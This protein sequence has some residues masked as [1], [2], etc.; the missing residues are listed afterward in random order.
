MGSERLGQQTTLLEVI[1]PTTAT[2]PS[3]RACVELADQGAVDPDALPADAVALLPMIEGGLNGSSTTLT[4]HQRPQI[5]LWR[6]A[7]GEGIDRAEQANECSDR[8]LVH[9]PACA[10]FVK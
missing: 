3:S 9:R 7:G 5:G 10:V 2:Q 1:F 4:P 8:A 6:A